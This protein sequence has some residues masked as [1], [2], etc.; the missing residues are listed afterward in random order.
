MRQKE[1]QTDLIQRRCP[2]CKARVDADVLFCQ[3]CGKSLTGEKPLFLTFSTVVLILLVVAALA[4]LTIWPGMGTALPFAGALFLLFFYVADVLYGRAVRGKGTG[5][6]G[7][8]SQER[9]LK[10]RL[11]EITA[12]QARIDDAEWQLD[13]IKDRY[14]RQKATDTLA[15]GRKLLE[16]QRK[17][18][19]YRLA[20]IALLRWQHA[21][22]PLLSQVGRV[23]TKDVNKQLEYLLEMREQGEH[24][25]AEWSGKSDRIYIDNVAL[26]KQA[27]AA[28]DKVEELLAERGIASAVEGVVAEVEMLELL[29]TNLDLRSQ[30]ALAVSD[31]AIGDLGEWSDLDREYERLKLE[32]GDQ[33]GITRQ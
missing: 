15:R 31:L 17:R 27:L 1:K 4:A 28:L 18:C 5:I 30:E 10:S 23:P 7:W 21:L 16:D 33:P 8:Q 12:R 14:R 32:E 11:A 9:V 24:L 22:Q 20:Q 6:P 19:E 2:E 25:I 26:I 29:G 13:H 3:E